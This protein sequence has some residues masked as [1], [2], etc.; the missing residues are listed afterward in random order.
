MYMAK[1]RTQK[2]YDENPEARAKKKAYDTSFN[3]KPKQRKKRAE[4][5]KENRRRGDYGNGDGMDLSHTKGGLKKKPQSKNRGS[6]GDTS[7]DKRA[8]G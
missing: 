6:K 8:R 5:N 7:G 3:R 1:K 4:L 2:Y